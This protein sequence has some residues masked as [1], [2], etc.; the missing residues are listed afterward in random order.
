MHPLINRWKLTADPFSVL[1]QLLILH[2]SGIS[3]EGTHTSCTAP[4][5]KRKVWGN[6]RRKIQEKEEEEE[7][8][9]DD[10]NDDDEDENW[11]ISR[12]GLLLW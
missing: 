5:T 2:H 9:E 10:D 6:D 12:A 7:E 4:M 3:L 11:Q 8:E 1:E